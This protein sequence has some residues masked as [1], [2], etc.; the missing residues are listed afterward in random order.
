MPNFSNIAHLPL[1]IIF[2]IH[3]VLVT[4]SIQG[5]WCPKSPLFYNALFFIC[6]MWAIQNVESDEPI[7]LALCVNF[8]SIFLDVVTLSIY[9][10]TSFGSEKFSAALM[11]INMFARCISNVYLLRIG[12]ARG[13]TLATMF[14]PGLIMGCGRRDYEDISRSIS[15]NSDF[16]GV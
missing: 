16:G 8:L 11:I 15:D 2:A 7:Q 13:G 6:L 1:K 4:W 3:L 12:Q 14:T 10:P 9:F 5:Y